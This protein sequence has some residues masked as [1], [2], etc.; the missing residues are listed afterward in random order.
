[1]SNTPTLEQLNTAYL[2]LLHKI[3]SHQIPN[4]DP[5]VTQLLSN[6]TPEKAYEIL[7]NKQNK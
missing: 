7:T 5:T 6:P 1:M 4:S 3:T 2:Q